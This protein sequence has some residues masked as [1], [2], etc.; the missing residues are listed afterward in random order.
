MLE[1]EK[2]MGWCHCGM[3]D[4]G[5]G[6]GGGTKCSGKEGEGIGVALA[7]PL[8]GTRGRGADVY[9]QQQQRRLYFVS[10]PLREV[11]IWPY[12]L[13]SYTRFHGGGSA[14]ILCEYSMMVSKD[15]VN[16]SRN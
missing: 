15:N 6:G 5:L 3:R 10:R 14:D 12:S 8:D 11:N 2:R 16:R 13:S 7:E 1:G 9:G 4:G